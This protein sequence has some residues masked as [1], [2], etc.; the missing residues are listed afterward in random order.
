M[1]RSRYKVFD[2]AKPHFLTCT[3]VQ[4]IKLFDF[5]ELRQVIVDSLNFMVK[6]D[7]L[8]I[9]AYVIMPNHIHLIALSDQL[10]KE[11]ASFKS[12]TARIIIDTLKS[13][14][15]NLILKRLAECKL[16]F[17]HDRTYQVWQEGSHPQEIQNEAM[18]LQK[19]DYIHY[20]PVRA[21][22][23]EDPIEWIYSSA[24]DYNDIKGPIEVNT[25]W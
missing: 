16:K 6:H 7:R 10:A 24:R 18:M 12:F 8:Q 19:I 9:Y 25:E 22:Y 14:Q 5:K 21:G 13:Q 20:N 23:I 15:E 1:A 11:M 2:T 3:V 17:K 4:W